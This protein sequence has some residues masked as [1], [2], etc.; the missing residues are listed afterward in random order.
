MKFQKKK[1]FDK[2]IKFANK[3]YIP[4]NVYENANHSL[5]TGNMKQDLENMADIMSL[6][7][8]FL[9]S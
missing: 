9:K 1:I 5:E 7:E 8:S 2:I 4:I 6:C 3:Q